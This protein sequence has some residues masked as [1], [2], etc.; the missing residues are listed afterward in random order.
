MPAREFVRRYF[1]LGGYKDGLVG[2]QLC[3][4]MS[5]Y[6]F[7]TYVRLRRLHQPAIDNIKSN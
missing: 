3:G 4:L 2:L 1:T 5:W 7:L 6:T